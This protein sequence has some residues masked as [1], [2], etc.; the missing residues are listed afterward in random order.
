MKAGSRGYGLMAGWF[1]NQRQT[2]NE[3]LT[4]SRNWLQEGAGRGSASSGP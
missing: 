1:A 4:L 3:S 2:Y